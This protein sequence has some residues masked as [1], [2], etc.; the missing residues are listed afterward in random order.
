M[1]LAAAGGLC[2]LIK[3]LLAAGFN[4]DVANKHNAKP[5]LRAAGAG[6]IEAIKTLLA[7]GADINAVTTLGHTALFWAAACEQLEA[8]KVLL[9]AGAK[10]SINLQNHAGVGP[11]HILAHGRHTKQD[12]EAL[13]LPYTNILAECKE[14]CAEIAQVLLKA[15]ADATLKTKKGQTALD[16]AIQESHTAVLSTL[17]LDYI[18][19]AC[20]AAYANYKAMTQDSDDE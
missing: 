16:L 2:D 7:A 13:G 19:S 3:Q 5:L 11:L 4:V 14:D 15:G 1:H 12:H 6:R 10:P 8:T 18:T 9:D 20:D 17:T